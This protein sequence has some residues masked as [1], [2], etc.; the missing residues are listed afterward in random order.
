MYKQP[1]TNIRLAAGF[2]VISFA[3]LIS[4]IC[5]YKAFAKV[6][7]P[8]IS[9]S[10][11]GAEK[12]AY[13]ERRDFPG[14]HKETSMYS[15]LYTAGDGRVYIGLCTHGGP[16]QFYQYY[17]TTDKIHHIADISEF[18]GEKG[19]GTRV[20]AKLHTRPVEDNEGR[21]YLGT[22]CEDGGPT[23]I[24][25][26]WP[27]H[28]WLRYDPKTDKL[29]DL[30]LAGG[31]WG[32]YGLAIDRKR[33]YLFATDWNGH[34]YR[35]DIE[36]KVTRDLGRVDDWDVIRH[37]AA[38]DEGNV[39]G[40]FPPRAQIWKYDAE[41]ERVYDLL[42]SIPYDATI[43]PRT[44]LNPM[45][46]RKAIWR[47]V[48]WDPVDKVIYGVNGGNSVLFR[49]DPRDGPE[50]KVTA[51]EK[52]CS[53]NFYHSDRKDVPY[54]TLA[55]TIGKDR[56]IYYAPVGL[57]FDFI[58]DLSTVDLSQ[59]LQGPP[60]GPYSELISYDIQKGKREYL[61]ILKTTDGCSVFGCGAAACGLD[62][63]IYLCGAVEAK[64]ANDAA[65]AFM[66]K[67]PFKMSLLIYKP[68]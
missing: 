27:G 56:K 52:L 12:Y 1:H 50:G 61:G 2:K 37:I 54:S 28:H 43:F 33:N 62:G 8:A 35:F 4:V 41:T 49:Y 17:P 20:T 64:D 38:D 18:L 58:H 13:V 5:P 22:M 14:G 68:K 45:L 7:S 59:N 40:C 47:V 23:N 65:G 36:R 34:L 30:G 66:E 60:K 42:V 21:I 25:P 15:G 6:K 9:T 67:C 39:Y 55:F 19:K 31:L 29:E 32:T 10:G 16:A 48:Q 53:E 63:T 24:E 26:S 3:L 44:M 11:E 51:L 46:E 57:A